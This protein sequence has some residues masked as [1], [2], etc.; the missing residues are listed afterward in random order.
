VGLHRVVGDALVVLRERLPL[1]D[2]LLVL[3]H[4]DRLEIVPGREMADEGLVSMPA[5][6]SSPTEKA[7][8]GMSVAFTPWLPS[9]L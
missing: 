4:L 7:T 3:R 6:S 9:S 1:G 8:T 2:E 5:N